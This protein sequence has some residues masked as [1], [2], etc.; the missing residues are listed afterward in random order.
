[1]AFDVVDEDAVYLCTG[2]PM[3]RDIEAV[4]NWLLNEEFN[5][6]FERECEQM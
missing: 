4:V 1:M 5:E 3:P 2:N 6:A